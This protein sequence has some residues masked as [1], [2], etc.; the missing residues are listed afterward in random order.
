M[1]DIEPLDSH[2]YR[3]PPRSEDTSNVFEIETNDLEATIKFV[4]ENN[5]MV[6]VVKKFIGSPSVEKSTR[7]SDV[8]KYPNY[9]SES[10]KG[11]L[12]SSTKNNLY[13][14][15]NLYIPHHRLINITTKITVR[16]QE[17]SFKKT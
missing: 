16:K 10:F 15:D 3:S 13:E 14:L 2:Q 9:G 6:S 8:Y 17:V 4:D 12:N 5:N 7:S 11:W 1:I